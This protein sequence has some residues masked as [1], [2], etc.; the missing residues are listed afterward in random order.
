MA[1][2]TAFSMNFDSLG[3]GFSV[4][5]KDFIDP[6]FFQIADRFFEFAHAYQFK[7]TF[8]VIGQDLEHPAVA[9][10]VK[11]WSEQGHE[12]GNHSYTHPQNIGCLSYNEIEREVL[13][14]HDIITRVCGKEPRGFIAPSWSTST[15]LIDILLKNGYLYDTSLVPSYV[16]WLAVAQNWWNFKRDPRRKDILQRKDR[17]ANLI[18]SRKPYLANESSLTLRQQEGLLILPLPVTPLFRWP[19]WHTLAF[20]LPKAMFHHILKTCLKNL[21]HFYYLIHPADLI[22]LADIP[23]EYQQM[24]T[25]HRL[26]V[27]LDQKKQLY[28]ESL[29]IIADR[30]DRMVTMEEMAQ[31]I[32]TSQTTVTS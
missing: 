3:W 32:S 4:K 1:G 15:N 2:L 21:D 18:G 16:L 22:T 13:K 28:E 19:C 29:K 5:N 31:S 20:A 26:E 10:R 11:Y 27:P 8:F 9:E 23:D 24:K 25:I 30:S 14:T 12:I 6:T 17:L 7:Y